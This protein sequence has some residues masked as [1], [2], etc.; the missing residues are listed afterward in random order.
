MQDI[1]SFRREPVQISFSV[2]IPEKDVAPDHRPLH[3]F[4]GRA[5][6]LTLGLG[7]GDNANNGKRKRRGGEERG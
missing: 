3:I 1:D 4:T 2:P 5:L 7:N 6:Q